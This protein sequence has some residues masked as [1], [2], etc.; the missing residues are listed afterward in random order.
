MRTMTTHDRE[1]AYLSRTAK[2]YS[3]SH[4]PVV[5][6]SDLAGVVNGGMRSRMT[7]VTTTTR[8]PSP[9]AASARAMAATGSGARAELSAQVMAEKQVLRFFGF[10]REAVP[11]S[12]LETSRVR[13][14]TLHYFIETGDISIYEPRVD[15]SGLPQ[16][17]IVRKGKIV[18]R[19]REDGSHEFMDWRDFTVADDVTIYGR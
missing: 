13:L 17:P 7:A 8:L 12:R 10:Y 4:E 14:V 15:N 6:G 5:S 9:D 1:A 16:G 11:E 19:E 2:L 3:T 18:K